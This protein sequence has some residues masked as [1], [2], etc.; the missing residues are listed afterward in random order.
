MTTQCSESKLDFSRVGFTRGGGTIRRRRRRALVRRLGN[1]RV[2]GGRIEVRG[3]AGFS[4]RFHRARVGRNP[5]TGT[6]APVP[7]KYAVYFRPGK[8]LRERVDREF[9]EPS[10]AQRHAGGS[11]DPQPYALT[12]Q[13]R[14]VILK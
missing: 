12:R 1:A 11:E 2:K 13:G 4:L 8:K 14:R 5:G 10:E 9:R 7:A 3:F 6:P